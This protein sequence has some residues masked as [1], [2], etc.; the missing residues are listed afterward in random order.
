MIRTKSVYRRHSVKLFL[1]SVALITIVSSANAA[2][3][4]GN[5]L[6]TQ[7]AGWTALKTDD[8]IL[9]VWNRT[10]LHFTLSAK[11]KDIGPMV[12]QNNIFFLV[13]EMI[14]RIQYL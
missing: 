9:F 10:G 1:V 12:D 5:S 6:I 4:A 11:G 3:P 13:D 7:E 2:A 14:L 8:G